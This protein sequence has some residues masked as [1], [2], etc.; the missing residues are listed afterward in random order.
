[1]SITNYTKIG[2][3]MLFSA[4]I[5]ST[6]SRFPYYFWNRNKFKKVVV[7]MQQIQ[8]VLGME[9]ESYTIK[10]LVICS[11]FLCYA[12]LYIYIDL[13]LNDYKSIT[14]KLAQ[15]INLIMEL[16]E[17]LLIYKVISEMYKQYHFINNKMG[18]DIG[19]LAIGKLLPISK[20]KAKN[21]NIKKIKLQ[22]RDNFL[23]RLTVYSDVHMKISKMGRMANDVFG[24]P[25]LYTLGI[26]FMLIIMYGHLLS[27]PIAVGIKIILII[28]LIILCY[29]HIIYLIYWWVRTADEGK[30][31]LSYIHKIWNSLAS[32]DEVDV[33][34]NHLQLITVQLSNSRP[35]FTAFDLFQIDWPAVLMLTGAASTYVVILIQ[36]EMAAAAKGLNITLAPDESI[37]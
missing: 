17:C 15:Y 19:F 32:N 6:F 35:E 24:I 2:H 36:F 18:S 28:I 7:K 31:T 23:N 27:Y 12:A 37:L 3:M 11:V 21:K 13:I 26:R 14:R 29:V 25:I 5:M 20:M 16:Y 34:V 22:E 8:R 4:N 9:E 33:R 1:M 10:N 30:L